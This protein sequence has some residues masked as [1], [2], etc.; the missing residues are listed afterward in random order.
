[1]AKKGIVNNL[2]YGKGDNKDFTTANLP[3][4]R[5]KQ[6]FYIFK[7]NYL[8][9][10]YYN[11]LIALCFLPALVYYIMARDYI[12]NLFYNKD[13][14]TIKANL[15]SISL[16]RDLPTGILIMLG[17]LIL[18][19]FTYIIRRLMWDEVV[20]FKTDFKKGLKN[21][22]KQFLFIGFLTGLMLFV[23]G[24][25]L[26][27]LLCS[28]LTLLVQIM[29]IVMLILFAI[30]CIISMMYMMNLASLYN[31]T[32]LQL[33]TYAFKLTLKDLL[34]NLGIFLITFVP[35]FIWLAFTKIFNLTTIF[36]L[37]IYGYIY[38]MLAFGELTMYSFDKYIN[39][40]QYPDFVRKGLST[41]GQ[42]RT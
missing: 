17:F 2:L 42:D 11:L 35:V 12:S 3:S 28:G 23:F 27:T 38:I 41:N 29:I 30:L 14:T 37:F 33:I 24:Y 18:P 32:N 7:R 4:T 25:G 5:R 21:S 13:I 34:K 8:K 15:L 10:F 26:S 39:V 1:M 9:L 22:Y 16:I 19:G 20:I 6:F 40:K 36:I 31:L